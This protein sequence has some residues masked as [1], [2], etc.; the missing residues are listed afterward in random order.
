MDKKTKKTNAKL[1]NNNKFDL[2]LKYGQ[3]R[4]KQVHN[5]F[6]NKKIEVKTERD[7][8]AKTGNIAIE[9]ECNGKPSGI[10]VTKCDYWIHVLAI[11]KKDYCKLV[12]PIDRIKK[13]TKKYKDRSRMLGDRNASKC[14]LIPLK[15]LFNKENIA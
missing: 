3:M 15:E 13:L 2:D 11:G 9:V 10:S 6:Y 14:I 7:W 12:F 1:N 8:W 5:M 4:E